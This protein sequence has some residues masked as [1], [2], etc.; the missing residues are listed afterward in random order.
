MSYASN[1][2]NSGPGIHPSE[3]N[4]IWAEAGSNLGIVNDNDPYPNNV[5]NTPHSLSNYLHLGGKT[6]RSYQEDTDINVTNNQPLPKSQYTVP[7]TSTNGVFAVA[8][9]PY[10][11]TDLRND[12]RRRR[13]REKE[14]KARR[15]GAELAG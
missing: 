14:A 5:S 11:R 12:P 4:Y 15:E 1:Y 6:W 8:A 10:T 3:P 13:R 2:L 9:A 7:L